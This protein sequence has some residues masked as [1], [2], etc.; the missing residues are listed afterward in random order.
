M[1]SMIQFNLNLIYP[2]S[3]SIMIQVPYNGLP[4][5]CFA[6]FSLI[7]KPKKDPENFSL[8]DCK[9]ITIYNA[10]FI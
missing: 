4:Y 7:D 1:Y 10:S 6:F 5:K 8:S 2:F 3:E 9:Y